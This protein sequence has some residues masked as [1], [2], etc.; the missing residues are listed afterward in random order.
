MRLFIISADQFETGVV[1]TLCFAG[2]INS[3]IIMKTKILK[4]ISFPPQ[5]I[6]FS[7]IAERART[8]SL[9]PTF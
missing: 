9:V 4:S 3:D 2:K 8:K 6:L 1:M 5:Q 7:R